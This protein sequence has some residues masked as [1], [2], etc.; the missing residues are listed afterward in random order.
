[1]LWLRQKLLDCASESVASGPSATR[2]QSAG[3]QKHPAR[4][5]GNNV[6]LAMSLTK[7][8]QGVVWPDNSAR[9]RAKSPGA[10]MSPGD[11]NHYP[12]GNRIHLPTQ[13]AGSLT[14][15][16]GIFPL[17]SC[18]K[19]SLKLHSRPGPAGD[20]RRFKAANHYLDRQRERAGGVP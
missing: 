15:R 17:V 14:G 3:A 5:E 9:S 2:I 19:P 12:A 20:G 18:R 4:M 6:I 16:S 13:W 1:M 7:T 10:G 8:R 11:P